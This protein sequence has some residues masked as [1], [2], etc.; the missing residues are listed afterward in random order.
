MDQIVTKLV[1]GYGLTGVIAGGLLWLTWTLFKRN[2]DLQ[3][4][5]VADLKENAKV[6]EGNTSSRNA[7]TEAIKELTEMLRRKV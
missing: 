4:E 5:R 2:E 6:I 3:K 1:D 7:H